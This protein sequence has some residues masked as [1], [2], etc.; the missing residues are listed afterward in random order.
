MVIKESSGVGRKRDANSVK[1][2]CASR[3]RVNGGLC[4]TR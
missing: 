3:V 4:K 2:E 1:C